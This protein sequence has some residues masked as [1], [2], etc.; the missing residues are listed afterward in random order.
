MRQHSFGAR[1]VRALVVAAVLGTTGV[2]LAALPA[3]ADPAAPRVTTVAGD[4]VV[5]AAWD[6]VDQADSY[7]VRVS[8]KR[9]LAHARRI[10]TKNRSVL[11]RELRNGRPYYLA[12]TANRPGVVAATAMRSR[13]VKA[14]AG[15]GVPF[16]VGRVS[17]V[18][19]DA[20]DQ[21][22]VDWTGGGR[23]RK[24]AVIAGSD[25]ITAQRSFH[26]AWF[27][28]TT[29]SITITVPPELKPYLG[30]G[31][32]NPVWVK[33]VQSNSASTDFG[34]SYDYARKYRPSPVGTWSF[35]RAMVPDAPTT[36]LTVA[37]LNTQSVG[38]TARYS[39]ANRWSERAPRVASAIQRSA[40]D[41]LMTAELATNVLGSCTN[42]VI[43]GDAY[44]C[45]GRTQLADLG[46]RLPGLRL[47][48]TDAYDRVM[49][50]M[51]KAP[52][53]NAKVTN[54]A[55]VFYSPD[56]LTLLD[57]GYFA[58]AMSPAE[59]FQ[60]VRGLGVPGWTGAEPIGSDRWL[61]W[62]KFETR[63]GSGRQFF[64]VAG[65]FPQGT[66]P[67]VVEARAEEARLLLPAID[68]LA[69]N[70]PV[71]LGADMNADAV[72]NPRAPQVAFMRAG[73]FDAAAVPEKRLRTGM[74]VST[75]NGSGPQQSGF[76][77]GYGSKPVHHPWETSRIDYILL[78]RSPYSYSYSNVLQLKA[79]GTFDR[80]MQGTDHN[81]QLA[82]IGIGSAG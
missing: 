3:H 38:A 24:V 80:T 63:D 36:R 22:R 34:P 25:V 46:R 18:P 11:L 29:R 61:S 79:D 8:T 69:G 2:G 30:G 44:A 55:H 41:L 14:V 59:S 58:P 56:K 6:A 48:G 47:A 15:S 4:R 31:T 42:H 73:W 62:A 12:V 57:H 43:S 50:R 78:R 40:P 52:R 54:G 27:P 16:P 71:V 17:A 53:W 75:A 5:T 7:T 23:A 26:S 45:R 67:A 68:A 28:A 51:R 70:L 9:S 13:V 76:D 19:G 33:V 82:S 64:A 37:E 66:A 81:M 77:P 60:N 39:R 74:K 21:V 10:V 20:A 49:D 32:G 72:R 35:A 1:R 65:H